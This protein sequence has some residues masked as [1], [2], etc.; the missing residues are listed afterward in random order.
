MSTSLKKW[1][2]PYESKDNTHTHLLLNGG[3]YTIPNEKESEFIKIYSDS[4]SKSKNLYVVEC[5]PEIFKYMIDVDIKD[6]EPWSTHQIKDFVKIIQQVVYQFYEI[7]MNVICCTCDTKKITTSNGSTLIK[8]GIHLIYPRHF[9]NSHDALL[10]RLAI[11]QKLTQTYGERHKENEWN[12]VIDERIYTANG[13]RMVGSDKLTTDKIT[14]ERHNEGRI[15]WPTFVMDSKGELR[16]FYY[17]RLINDYHSL[18]IDT[19]IRLV[20]VSV[21]IPITKIPQW[22]II[23]DGLDL[24]IKESKKKLESKQSRIQVNTNV[25]I[26]L[27]DFMNKKLPNVYKNQQIKSVQRY[28]DG[29]IL[30]I[31]DSRHC[32]NI[33]R[34]H[35]SCGI[36]FFGT[37]KGIYQKCLCPCI[38]LNERIF[39]KD[40]TSSCF[41][42]KGS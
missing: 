20:P 6:K 8:T 32:L 14:K 9:T 26:K 28:P 24:K 29:N 40:Y 18:I 5:R 17:K 35:H 34:S 3:K 42:Y 31:T 27:Q 16:N 1:L 25:F 36:Y 23:K 7:D 19:S 38:N 12:D 13:Y 41:E 11:V 37:T 22:V 10:I 2:K 21:H 30:I 4:I 39:C 33:G 15:Y